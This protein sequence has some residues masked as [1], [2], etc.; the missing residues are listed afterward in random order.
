M[1]DMMC[2]ET[3]LGCRMGQI[4]QMI[5]YAYWNSG[6]KGIVIGTKRGR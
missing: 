1:N 2:K 3:D 6:C 5:R 4:E